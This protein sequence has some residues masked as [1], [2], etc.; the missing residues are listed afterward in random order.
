MEFP[1]S[2]GVGRWTLRFCVASLMV[3]AGF[4]GCGSSSTSDP[5]GGADVRRGS[6]GVAGTGGITGEG[7]GETSSGGRGPP[8]QRGDGGLPDHFPLSVLPLLPDAGNLRG[9]VP[10]CG[11]SVQ[12]G[13]S[14]TEDP[15]STGSC[16]P[17]SG[18]A[19]C[20]CPNGTWMCF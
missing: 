5:D 15:G 6:G 3:G 4:F 13:A 1:S 16:K 2:E 12:Q 14:C 9:G 7:G 17:T 10:T 8:L 19:V 18:G 11:A 20:L